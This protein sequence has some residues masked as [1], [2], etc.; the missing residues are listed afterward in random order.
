MGA[1]TPLWAGTSPEGKELNG[2]VCNW[3]KLGDEFTNVALGNLQYL[4]PWARVGVASATT[5]D[6]ALGQRPWDY[7]EEQVKK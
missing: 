6:Q 7:L 2:K 5:Q 1:L 3:C 4:I